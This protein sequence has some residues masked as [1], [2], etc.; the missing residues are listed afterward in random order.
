ME[1]LEARCG[2]LVEDRAAAEVQK[3]VQC[4]QFREMLKEKEREIE[5]MAAE[6]RG[7][8][9]GGGG[10][11]GWD[12]DVPLGVGSDV[13]VDRNAFCSA[14]D[15]RMDYLAKRIINLYYKFPGWGGR[16][17]VLKVL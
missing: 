8:D 12:L 2:E 11:Q 13:D 15:P 5:E 16:P 6:G 3:E 4:Q 9:G 17:L 14:S 1:R 10:G 7:G